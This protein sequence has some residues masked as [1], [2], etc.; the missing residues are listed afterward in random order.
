MNSTP[1]DM[2]KCAIIGC[3]NVGATTAYSLMLDRTFSEIVLIDID[4]KKAGGEA[5]D[6]NHGMPFVAP[7]NIY[8]GDYSDL[9]DASIIIIT[10]GANQRPGQ[11]RTDLVRSNVRIFG[12][13]VSNI[14]KYTTD[15]ILL[16]VTNPVDILTYT[17]L[18]MSGYPT[19][20]VIGSGTVLDTARLK[21][22][23]GEYLGVDSRNIHS[24]IIGEHGDSELAVWSCATVSGIPLTDFCRDNCL[25]CGMERM[26][27]M[28]NQVKNSAYEIIE[29]K[30]ATYYAIAE[31]VRRIVN[32]IV[33]DEN[34][35]LPVSSLLTGQYGLNDVCLGLPCIV[36][37]D[38]IK[39]VLELPLSEAE[40]GALQASAD[41]MREI[42]SSLELEP[43]AL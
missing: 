25:N 2:R 10:A 41:K 20:R 26:E 31:A 37:R 30:G 24:F 17:T 21:Y 1:V 12:S 15:A 18:K 16:V 23:A 3:G 13:I 9:S 33:H 19:Q 40:Y 5:S 32:A 8:S 29:A 35:I 42:I 14:I 38:G 4:R 6:L 34:S 43:S 39:R 11:T 22:M 36:G 27:Q 28:Y 7:M